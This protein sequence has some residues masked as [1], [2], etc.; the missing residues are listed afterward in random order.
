MSK[1][2]CCF[3]FLV[4]GNV[5]W[6]SGCGGG[7][8]AVTPSTPGTPA[9]YT[10]VAISDIHFNPLAN[11]ALF[12]SLNAQ[13]A[14]QWQSI[15]D[16]DQ[17]TNPAPP[18]AFGTDPNYPALVLA[19]A[20][21]K[22][23][24]GSSPVV[25][26]SGDMLGHYLPWY[27]CELY[28]NPAATLTPPPSPA[29]TLNTTGTAAMQSFLD[30]TV[31][32]VSMEI[33]ANVG[34]VPVIFVPGNIDTYSINGTGPDTSFLSDNASTFYTQLLNSSVNQASFQSTFTT[35]GSYSMQLPGSNVLAIALDSN[36]FAQSPNLPP[37]D[38]YAELTW[39]DSQLSAAQS[40]GQKVWLMMHVP[41]G[42]NTT[43]TA[44][45]AAK[46]V[47]PN[48]KTDDE[49]VMMWQAQYQAEFMLILEK[50]PGL[51]AMGITGHTHMDEFRVLPTGDVLFG[52]PGISPV[53][54]NNPAFK[55][56]TIAQASQM[57]M[58][59][60]TID[61]N[62]AASPAPAQYSSFYTFSTAF[63]A[64]AGTTL[65]SS[66]QQLYPQLTSSAA[67]TATFINY[68]D[69]GNTT[70]FPYPT[71][72]GTYIMI[73]WNMANTANWALYSCGFSQMDE[74]D[75]VDCVNSQ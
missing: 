6:M 19:L 46:G 38:P 50:Y 37:L 68:Y 62:L 54:G 69:A 34:N 15:F 61:Y 39:L 12:T 26:F 31:A 57:P 20:A 8:S 25:L 71:G 56:F 11:P 58:D 51:I 65:A 73:P 49:A 75:Y 17:H 60:Q 9:T 67:A 44:Q 74:S 45:N 3:I 4:L 7:A 22:Q 52:I 72:S 42:A 1:I 29:C 21:L 63:G 27:F 30:K 18:A 5:V 47:A 53:F 33:R 13:P 35:L 40:A 43:G 23:N 24:L 59:Y 28:A 2:S 10:V 70:S 32:F 14:N 36:P 48:P 66:T 16:N 64:T 55:I 41:P